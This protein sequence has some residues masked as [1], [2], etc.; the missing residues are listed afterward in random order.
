MRYRVQIMKSLIVYVSVEHGNTEKVAKAISEVLGAE[1]KE[2][3][4]VDPQALQ[5]YELIGFGSGIFF[6]K[7]HARL[8]QLVTEMPH[9][10]YKALIFSTSG[11]GK[12][13][14]HDALRKELERKGCQIIGDFACKGWDTYK[15]FKL[16]GGINKGRP[17]EN[18]LAQAREFARN[19]GG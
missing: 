5:N 4:D 11:Y 7:F 2:A 12:T 9:S 10:S 15:P 1:L 8:L 19:L 16:V 3:K 17:D 18:D 6:S 13:N 14:V